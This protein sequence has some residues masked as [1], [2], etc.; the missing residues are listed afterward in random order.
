MMLELPPCCSINPVPCVCSM[1]EKRKTSFS[2]LDE[3]ERGW[4][5][6]F[7]MGTPWEELFDTLDDGNTAPSWLVE[8]SLNWGADSIFTIDEVDPLWSEGH[9]V[10]DK[11]TMESWVVVVELDE[12]IACFE[13]VP[14]MNRKPVAESV[15]PVALKYLRCIGDFP[16]LGH[17][18]INP[19]WLP[20]P[21]MEDFMT[22][23]LRKA[24]QTYLQGDPSL[25]LEKWLHREYSLIGEP[26][27]S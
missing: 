3:Y 13:H 25:T 1:F 18:T 27:V 22:I 10:T 11:S 5:L 20:C 6:Q 7:V 12:T 2:Q 19:S 24:G 14:V 15:W 8:W 23:A 16:I 9:L 21:V 26:P 17:F 4:M